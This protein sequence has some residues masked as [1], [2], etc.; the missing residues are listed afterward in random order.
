[1]AT[2]PQEKTDRLERATE[3]ITGHI[4]GFLMSRAALDI[5]D[6][7]YSEVCDWY[8]ELVK[9]RLYDEGT[10]R[11][12]L[13]ATLLHVLERTVAL[14]HPIMPF[15]TEELWLRRYGAPG[16]PLIAAR[17]PELGEELLDP[18]AEDEIDWLI[19]AI[20]GLRA[21]RSELDVPPAAKLPLRVRD[22]APATT[23]R[24]AT[25]R[26]ALLRLARLSEITTGQEP[27]PPG[28][29]QVVVDE[30]TFA[31]PLAGVVGR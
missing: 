8:L 26:E 28:A 3:T 22:A 23:Q 11:S 16:G 14:L 13:S 18:A 1:M 24:L 27:V 4:D 31:V 25:H 2:L 29:L 10:D 6:F 15:V 9:P 30:A 20:T 7:I 12:A 17:W 21:A 5:Y 19:R